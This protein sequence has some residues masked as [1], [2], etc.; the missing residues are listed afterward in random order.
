MELNVFELEY[1]I[2]R[3]VFKYLYIELLRDISDN[4]Q[5]GEGGVY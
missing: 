3:Y 5:G 1:E 2:G 4:D